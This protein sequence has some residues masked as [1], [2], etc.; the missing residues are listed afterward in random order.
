MRRELD[1]TTSDG[2]AKAVLFRPD[3]PPEG[4]PLRGV[5]FYM[6]A[7]G[8]RES[9]F[10]M[11]QRL[12][13]AGYVVLLPDLFYRY[14]AYGPFSGASFG[15]EAE[16]NQIMGMIRGTTQ[17]MTARDTEAFLKV[18]DAEGVEGPIGAV[19]YCMGGGRALTAAGT[20]PD[21]IA[22]AA[23]FHGA[24]LASEAEDSPHR[25]ADRMKA[26]VYV[27]VAGVDNS[28]PPEQ[29]ARLAESLRLAGVDSII[30]NYVGMQ[31]GWTVPDRDGVYDEAG[32]ERHW[33]RLLTLFDEGLS[34]G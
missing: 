21:R 25:L 19:G 2:T 4:K 29:S 26:K 28:F 23:S 3:Q 30:E 34:R 6:D 20:Y 27:G 15:I 12:A 5:I 33:K 31:H 11:A 14:G 1:I 32:A 9:M 24:A 7:M 16:R 10:S 22:A 8:L 13:D 18:L 17:A